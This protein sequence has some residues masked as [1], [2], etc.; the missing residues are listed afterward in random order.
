MGALLHDAPATGSDGLLLPETYWEEEA[1]ALHAGAWRNVL[2]GRAL[3]L[4]A[5]AQVPL[6]TLFARSPVA[7]WAT[8]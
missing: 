6:S 3:P 8:S 4:E 7:V 1:A 5:D 2:D